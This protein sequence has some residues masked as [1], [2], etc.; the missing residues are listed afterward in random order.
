MSNIIELGARHIELACELGE[1]KNDK[2]EARR[3]LSR[4]RLYHQAVGSGIDLAIKGIEHGED[5]EAAL[6]MLRESLALSEKIIDEISKGL[7]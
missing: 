1:T 7:G 4:S 5:E 3:L 2:Q 6:N